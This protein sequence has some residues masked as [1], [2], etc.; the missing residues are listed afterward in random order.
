MYYRYLFMKFH[1]PVWHNAFDDAS[2]EFGIMQCRYTATPRLASLTP[3]RPARADSA[4]HL[5]VFACNN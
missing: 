2:W 4:R 1:V 5:A 3:A